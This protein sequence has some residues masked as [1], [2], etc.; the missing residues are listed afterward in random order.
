[1]FFLHNLF[2]RGPF[3]L[4]FFPRHYCSPACSK[5]TLKGPTVMPPFTQITMLQV[6]IS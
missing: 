3:H 2:I 6:L 4:H 1:M 5:A